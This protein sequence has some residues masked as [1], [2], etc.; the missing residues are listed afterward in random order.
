MKV[1][2]LKIVELKH[3][4]DLCVCTCAYKS[5]CSCMCV[6]LCVFMYVFMCVCIYACGNV[7][8][9]MCVRAYV[10]VYTHEHV[11]LSVCVCLC[12]V[13]LRVRIIYCMPCKTHALPQSP[14][15]SYLSPSLGNVALFLLLQ[16]L[17]FLSSF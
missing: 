6:C 15:Y 2:K 8:M 14:K 11:S 5:I 13:L 16:A 9:H 17:C 12:G 1:S 10:C 7:C 3:P 4:E